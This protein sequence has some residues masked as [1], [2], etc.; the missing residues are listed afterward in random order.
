M[1]S[2]MQDLTP[3]L[4]DQALSQRQMH[5]TTEPSRCPYLPGFKQGLPLQSS[6]GED[7][8]L[9]VIPVQVCRDT[10]PTLHGL[11]SWA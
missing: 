1:L 4:Q 7:S 5:L 9:G 10:A 6:H 11:E 3:G 8:E 2:L